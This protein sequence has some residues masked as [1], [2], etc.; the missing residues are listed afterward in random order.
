MN[1]DK[2]KNTASRRSSATLLVL[3]LILLSLFPTVSA[4]DFDNV[5]DYDPIT[6]TYEITNLLGLGETLA[7]I[8]LNSPLNVK[9]GMG[10][11]KV[12]EFQLYNFKKD[13]SNAFKDMNFYE[14]NDLTKEISRTFD[15]KYLDYVNEEVAIYGEVCNKEQKLI[16]GTLVDDCKIEQT[17]K[18]I[19]S[20]E[21]WTKF[22]DPNELPQ[23]KDSFTIA[24]F[25]DVKKDD[26]LEWI[27]VFFGE[28]LTEWATWENSLN[29]DIIVFYDYQ[30]SSMV[31]RTGN[32]YDGS[33]NG[34][35][36]FSS[37]G[38]LGKGV[39]CD[40]GD[41][42]I[43]INTGGG[44]T[45]SDSTFSI[46][47]WVK[48][49]NT[50]TGQYLADFGGGSDRNII[51]T[52]GTNLDFNYNDNS[53]NLAFGTSSNIFNGAWH[54][55]IFTQA[56]T[57]SKTYLDGVS[58][59]NLTTSTSQLGTTPGGAVLCAIRS[60]GGAV[61]YT[62]MQDELM[63]H[64]RTLTPDEVVNYY[65]GG[66]PPY[67]QEYSDTAP[68]ITF[69]SPATQNY[70]TIP[71]NL[72]FDF[73]ASDNNALSDVKFYVNTVLNQTNATGINNTNYIFPL[74]L[75]DGDYTV[76]AKATDN[77]SLETDTEER[78]Y[79]IDSTAPIITIHAPTNDAITYTTLTNITL[80][81]TSS[82]IHL[83]TCW[84][85]TND[86]STNIIY[87][88][89]STTN[90]SLAGGNKTIYAFA[91]DTFGNQHVEN[92]TFLLNYIQ[93][94]AIYDS[95]VIEGENYTVALNISASYLSSIN[96]TL[97]YNGI[98]YNVTVTTNGNNAL[99][100][101]NLTAPDLNENLEISFNWTFNL[102]G[103]D[104]N[105]SNYE[106]IIFELT[107]LFFS[108][109][110]DDKALRFDIQDEANLSSLT[111]DIEFN[112]KYGISNA[113]AN[114]VFGSL[115]GVS[116]FYACINATV[117]PNY[118]IGYGEIQYRDSN[119]VDR[120]YYLFEGR[121]ISNNT[122]T[123]ITLRDLI[124]I[125][126][127]SFL[128]T[129]EDTS[130][131]IYSEKYTALWRW[132]PDLNEYQIVEMGKTDDDGQTVIHV[133][134]EDVD[135]RI[136]LYD[137]DGTLIKLDNPRRFVCT[138]AP[139]SLTI[140]V[141]AG[142]VD[143]SSVFDVQAEITYNETSGVFLLIY[144]DPNQL[145]SEMR[146]LVT[147]ETGTNTLII[148]NDTSSGFSGA[149]S[150]NT[151]MY[152]GLKKAVAYRSASPELPIA[153]K[154]ISQ[155]NT[156]FNSGFGLFISVILWLAIVLSGFGNNPIWTIILSVV[157]LIPALIMGSINIAIFTAIAVL[158]SIIIHFIKRAVAR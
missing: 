139:C 25:T 47:I 130:L 2:E 82:D 13:Y 95:S 135:Y 65:N 106:M 52:E 44:W 16:N 72:N 28:T 75:G 114:E 119:Y 155:I 1:F 151:S 134:T 64:D 131:N 56:G 149:M 108:A 73:T 48:G 102:N 157:G 147:R 148:C 51:R 36:S 50:A 152:N 38:I 125:D 17:G 92:T 76:Y 18:E 132:Y 74:T 35:A 105:S 21:I 83:N 24:I 19:I 126:Q 98:E 59:T 69:N 121:V 99:L 110:C 116:T 154:V 109:S 111:G 136:G 118:T 12:A 117:S 107:P 55:L 53:D 42:W 39:S 37:D 150:C 138:S 81:V 4:F 89:N 67:Y 27:P 123:N 144:N 93:E 127:T 156:T 145:T 120:R 85:N 45:T 34:G 133:E 90:I 41:D 26:Y 54:N 61:Q 7:E 68:T 84:H 129:M 113:T 62:G 86:N 70:T 58:V 140:R 97:L 142:D 137:T 11:Q 153:Q 22:S 57:A 77:A 96:G 112:F 63:I 33:V 146:F 158:A 29:T 71:Q 9:V 87:T 3:T 43:G 143:Y 78:R 20:K 80:N 101:T 124:T 94:N 66:S 79:V 23:T 30:N 40:G 88:C 103:V 49:T 91:N 104:Y 8:R 46:S 15:Y 141:G 10:Y 31:D 5:K 100:T 14:A 115:S 6:R 60:S 32:G 128:L 122:L